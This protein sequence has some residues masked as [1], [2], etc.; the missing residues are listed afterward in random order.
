MAPGADDEIVQEIKIEGADAGAQ[1]L[2]NLGEKG[3]QAFNKIAEAAKQTDGIAKGLEDIG[4]READLNKIEAAAHKFGESLRGV[5]EQAVQV[6]TEL[7]KIAG[8]IAQISAA[9]VGAM[10][11]AAKAAANAT[12]AVREAALAAGTT[13]QAFQK[14]AFAAEQSGAS[15]GKL[16][17]AFSIITAGGDK[18]EQ[19]LAKLGV[20][21]KDGSG[22]TR[23]ASEVFTEIADKIAAIPDPV[24]RAEA[25][26]AI[27]GRRMGPGLL[28]LL[29]EGSTGI[30]KLGKDAERLGLVFTTAEIAVG[31][32]FQT[33]LNRT[34]GTIGA[35][36][37]RIG[38]AF[39]PGFAKLFDQITEAVVQLT[40][41]VLKLAT[42]FGENF[43]AAVEKVGKV[44]G[45][46]GTAIAGVAVSIASI[47]AGLGVLAKFLS[48]IASLFRAAFAPFLILG[49]AVI[50]IFTLLFRSAGALFSLLRVGAAV[51][52]AVFGGVT[53]GAVLAAAAIGFL[54]VTLFKLD[55]TKVAN[56]AKSAWA[57]I[58]QSAISAKDAIVAAWG[59]VTEFFS[60]I[61]EGVKT[62]AGAAKDFVVG[63]WNSVLQFFSDLWEGIKGFASSAW[64]A[65]KQF[66]SDAKD[67]VVEK[68]NAVVAFFQGVWDSLKQMASDAWTFIQDLPSKAKDFVVEKWN[69]LIQFFADLWEKIKKL[70]ADAATSI[71]KAW[72]DLVA[73]FEGTWV[74]RMV[75]GIQK[76]IDWF[77]KLGAAQG[78]VNAE[79]GGTPDEP[80]GFKGGGVIRGRGTGTSDSILAWLSNGEGVLT[81]RALMHYGT[82]IVGAIN[83]LQFPRFNMGGIVDALTNPLDFPRF[84]GG[85]VVAATSGRHGGQPIILNIGG[86]QFNLIAREN[87]TA[88]RLGRYANK[89]RLS[90]AGRKPSYYGS[91]G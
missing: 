74:G 43:T 78:A 90:S 4:K 13:T 8:A 52:A 6:A 14:M 36:A 77:K 5:A 82:G 70:A 66:A 54:V 56:A 64:E 20:T 15:V 23:E 60:N 34:T 35:L 88:D 57:S 32:N 26:I 62:A 55:W 67:F 84:A 49:R 11:A 53:L 16:Q 25:A 65:I 38:L 45:P 22:H 24:R 46:T 50:S 83:N 3:E 17:R 19:N 81:A 28:P 71:Q 58:Q 18:L 41:A 72:E 10:F 73:W 40:P 86:E 89:R 44:L 30:Q 68:W 87:D 31:H 59:S 39:G 29:S 75:A 76:V 27:F 63:A 12:E 61:W 48:P 91:S 51:G 47:V 37:D 85:G 33:A 80:S 2:E 1:S 69:E 79:T 7:P 21:L 42:A 9:I